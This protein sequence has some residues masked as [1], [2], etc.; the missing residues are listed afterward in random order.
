MGV[1]GW[2]PLGDTS[3][4]VALRSLAVA[5]TDHPMGEWDPGGVK[6]APVRGMVWL[7]H[8]SV[9]LEPSQGHLSAVSFHTQTVV[10]AKPTLGGMGSPRAKIV[11]PKDLNQLF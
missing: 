6:S 8:C 2:S 4:P 1:P 11:T 5:L 7:W 9:H 10:L 3:V